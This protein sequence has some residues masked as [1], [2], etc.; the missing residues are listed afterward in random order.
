MTFPILGLITWDFFKNNII[1]ILQFFNDDCVCARC[2]RRIEFS[3][4]RR[5]LVQ[6]FIIVY[7]TS[8]S[9]MKFQNNIANEC[10][11]WLFS[12]K[13][14]KKDVLCALRHELWT[15]EKLKKKKWPLKLQN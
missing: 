14:K 13:F 6:F 7:E 9:R 8:S 2:C 12:F 4:K 1:F 5:K 10:Q 15:F 11:S 3:I